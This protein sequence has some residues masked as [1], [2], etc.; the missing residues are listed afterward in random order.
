MFDFVVVTEVGSAERVESLFECSVVVVLVVSDVVEPSCGDGVEHEISRFID[1]IL[2]D[3]ESGCFSD[4]LHVCV[5]VRVISAFASFGDELGEEVPSSIDGGLGA[6]GAVAPTGCVVFFL[7][8][9]AV[10]L[11]D[12]G[13]C[14]CCLM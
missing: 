6:C 9:G 2:F 14:C 12:A 3:D 4:C 1:E 7:E 8:E 5:A 13:H 10:E 11:E